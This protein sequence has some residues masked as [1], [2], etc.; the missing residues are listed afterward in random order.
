MRLRM[1]AGNQ[2]SSAYAYVDCYAEVIVHVIAKAAAKA[3]AAADCW[4]KQD[5]IAIAEVTAAVDAWVVETDKC[6]IT[7][8]SFGNAGTHTGGSSGTGFVRPT[9]A[10]A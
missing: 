5:S 9:T 2:A 8:G 10:P 1:G 4:P 3:F 6:T 7:E